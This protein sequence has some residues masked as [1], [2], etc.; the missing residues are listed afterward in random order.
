M[1]IRRYPYDG[2]LDGGCFFPSPSENVDNYRAKERIFHLFLVPIGTKKPR[3]SVSDSL[4]V[5]PQPAAP[6]SCS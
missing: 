1:V 5:S 3:Q 2:F 6:M 4:A